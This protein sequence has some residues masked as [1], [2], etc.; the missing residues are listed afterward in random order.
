VN[1]G[2]SGYPA[3]SWP[4]RPRHVEL[5][6]LRPTC[7]LGVL[8]GGSIFQA[9]SCIESS[10]I[11]Y[12][13]TRIYIAVCTT[14][15]IT[16]YICIYTYPWYTPTVAVKIFHSSHPVDGAILGVLR[17]QWLVTLLPLLSTKKGRRDSH[18]ESKLR[19]EIS[20]HLLAY[21]GIFMQTKSNIYMCLQSNLFHF[22]F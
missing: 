13:I 11:P 5:C 21:V 16:T 1:C 20:L 3:I 7:A 6:A 12:I 15:Y 22:Y 4:Q 2:F 19:R 14:I 10:V 18:W 17:W 9:T 8:D